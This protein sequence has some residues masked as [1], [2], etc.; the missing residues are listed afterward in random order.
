VKGDPGKATDGPVSRLINRPIAVW[1]ARQIIRLGL[2]LTPNQVSV[3]AFLLGAAAA[4][5]SA[6]GHYLAAGVLIQASSVIDGVD[7]AIA[8]LRGVASRAGGFLDTM[9]DR[10]A[11]ILIYLGLT[12]GPIMEGAADPLPAIVALGLGLSGDLMVSYLHVRGERD[13]GTH[14]SLIGPLDSI[15][16]RDVR[17]LLLAAITAAGHPIIAMISAGILGHVYV[18]VKSM[19]LF[20]YIKREESNVRV[21]VKKLNHL[22]HNYGGPGAFDKVRPPGRR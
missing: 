5:A 18:A 4:S 13:S 2:P 17:L 19:Y 6:M 8:R 20:Y 7:G 22:N 21:D 15:A 16:S 9:L 12:L 14:P 3:L 1:I 11:D 10:Y